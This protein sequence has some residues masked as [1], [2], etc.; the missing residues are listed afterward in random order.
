MLAMDSI[1]LILPLVK[2]FAYIGYR[3]CLAN[4]ERFAMAVFDNVENALQL[5]RKVLMLHG[6]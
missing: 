3:E 6:G 1:K 2:I 5:E 4:Q